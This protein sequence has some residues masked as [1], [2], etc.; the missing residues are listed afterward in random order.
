MKW[1]H[2]IRRSRSM[3]VFII[4]DIIGIVQLNA[5]FLSTVLT[6]AQFGWLILGIGIVGKILRYITK[7]PLT[8][9]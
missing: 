4:V 1:F 7:E 9:K 5:D 2:R 3:I 8:N 6:P